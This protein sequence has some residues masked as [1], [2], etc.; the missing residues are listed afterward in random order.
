MGPE[1]RRIAARQRG[2][3][4]RRQIRGVVSRDAVLRG[5]DDGRLREVFA[6]VYFVG[7]GEIS[8]VALA[9]AALLATPPDS[10]LSHRTAGAFHRILD[11]WPALPDVITADRNRS[12]PDGIALHRV[13]QLPPHHV[14]TKHR[15]RVTTPERTLLDLAEVLT[16]EELEHAIGQAE[17]RKLIRPRALKRVIDDSHGR[18]GLKPLKAIIGDGTP[19]PTASTL[20][21]RFLELLKDAELPAP[22]VNERIGRYRPDFLWPERRVIVETDGW[23]AHGGRIAFEADRQRDAELV[24][25]GYRVMRITARRLNDKP[26]AAL[27]RLGALLLG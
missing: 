12:A 8:A 19:L 14:I 4:T 23:R 17:F 7:A 10:A 1:V 20:E 13:R 21:R 5:V 16:T 25:M 9:H 26:L 11:L 27:T 2:I 24:V 22:R 15:L 3:V 6:G 18:R